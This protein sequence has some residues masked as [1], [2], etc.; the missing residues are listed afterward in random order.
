M[1]VAF[2]NFLFGFS[3]FDLAVHKSEQ[4]FQIILHGFDIRFVA[5]YFFRIKGMTKNKEGIVVKLALNFIQHHD[6]VVNGS[7]CTSVDKC[8][9]PVKYQ[10]AHMGN[11]GVREKDNTV[12]V[13]MRR[14]PVICFYIFLHFFVFPGI[15]IGDI[16]I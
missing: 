12:S 16:G 6:P 11:I 1:E 7:T 14:S 15:A 8:P 3:R 13:G 2:M 4:I 10:V 9:A 5:G